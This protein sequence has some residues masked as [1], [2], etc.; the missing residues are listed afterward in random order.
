MH[1]LSISFRAFLGFS[2]LLLLSQSCV[3]HKEMV[4]LNAKESVSED[5]KAEKS[6][7]FSNVY[8]FKP[9]QIRPFDQLMIKINAFDG[10][11]ED[12]L[13]REFSPGTGNNN[14]QNLEYNPESLYFNSYSVNDS[15]YIYLPVVE[16]IK[17]VGLTVAELKVLLD[18]AYSPYLKYSQSTIKLANMRFTVLGEVNNPGVYYLYNEQSS[19][20]DAISEAGDFTDFA[21]RTKVKLIR[22]TK[23]G[24]QTIYLNLNRSDFVLTEYFQI[25]PADVL[26]VEPIK[27]KSWDVSANSLSVIFSAVSLGVLVTNIFLGR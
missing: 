2:L 7:G 25:R 20:L 21:N 10:K 9:Y 14:G 23:E 12:F 16:K 4:S 18:E 19:L 27:A 8:P 3:K 13:N 6:M 24:S 15:G 26:Y 11:T 5:L 1:M 17:V 22:Q